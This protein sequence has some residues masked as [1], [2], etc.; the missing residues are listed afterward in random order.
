MRLRKVRCVFKTEMSSI[1]A[2]KLERSVAKELARSTAV[3]KRKRNASLI[4]KASVA[5]QLTVTS[6]LW[7]H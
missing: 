2:T 4:V 6:A 7:S 5:K 3:I 1:D